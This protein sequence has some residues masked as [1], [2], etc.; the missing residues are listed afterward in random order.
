M[1]PNRRAEGS[2]RLALLIGP[3]LP[4]RESFRRQLAE[5]LPGLHLRTAAGVDEAVARLGSD[6]T[7]DAV[8]VETPATLHEVDACVR[9]WPAAACVLVVSAAEGLR[10]YGLR[11]PAV[12]LKPDARAAE[13][14]A[15]LRALTGT[16]ALR[17]PGPSAVAEA[18]LGTMAPSLS[19]RER[20]T[21]ALLARGCHL[22]EVASQL[23][24]TR[25][26][27]AGFI[28]N[29][30][31]KLNV[32]TRAEATLEAARLGLAPTRH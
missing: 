15:G 14:A 25:N 22:P 28:K 4:G 21:L 24:V 3:G 12:E 32:S 19:P 13:F 27:A 31:R 6:E 1:N 16:G 8:F 10:L 30:Y 7:P 29:V 9:R 26:T 11:L 5:A 18:P 23:G 2:L 17:A 20:E